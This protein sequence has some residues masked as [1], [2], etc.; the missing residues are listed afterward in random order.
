MRRRGDVDGDRVAVAHGGDRPAARR[1][2]GD[3]AGHEAVGGA[4]EAPVGEQRD[5]LAEP[6]PHERRGDRE[7]LA[8]PGAARG[9][10]VAD[11]DDVARARSPLAVTAAIASSSDSKTRA[12]PSWWRRSW[13][14]S[15]TTQPSGARFPRRIASPPVGL[16]GSSSGRTTR[17]PSASAGVARVLADGPAGDRGRVAVQQPGLEQA[18]G[19]RRATPPACVEVD[20]DVLPAGLEVGEQRGALADAVEVVDAQRSTPASRAT[21]SRCRTRVGRAAAGRDRGDRVLQRLARDDLARALAARSTSITSRPASSADL[22]LGR[23]LGRDHRT[24]PSGEMPM[25]SKAIAIVLAVNWPPQAPGAGRGR[26]PPSS[27][28]SASVMRARGVGADR[29][30]DVLDRDVATL[31]AAGRD[32]AAVEHQA[33]H[34]EAQP[35]PSRFRGSSCRS[36]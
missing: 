32:R 26:R 6:L 30:E 2:G 15:L 3:V 17:W 25:T 28:S 13:P 4:G 19:Q 34:V 20:R 1:L 14:A 21:A 29:L 11:H 22:G 5:V 9:A 36:R 18:L 16:I 27:C 33:G 12:G 7:H 8:H 31:E 24:A 10:L 35:A 23:V